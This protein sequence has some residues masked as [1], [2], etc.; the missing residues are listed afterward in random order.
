MKDNDKV[1]AAAFSV[2]LALVVFV[3][4]V[5]GYVAIFKHR[6]CVTRSECYEIVD[7][8]LTQIYD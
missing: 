7:S 6:D 1:M 2:V 5:T 3:V 8:V 4:L